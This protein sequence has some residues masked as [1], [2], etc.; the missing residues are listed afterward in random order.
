MRHYSV[1][2]LHVA[3]RPS[4]M[5]AGMLGGVCLSVVVLLLLLPLPW[6]IKCL[7]GAMVVAATAWHLGRYAWSAQTITALELEVSGKLRCYSRAK[8]WRDVEVLGSSFVTPKLTVLN[9][10]LPGERLSRHVVLLP[11]MVESA[12]FRRL[13]VWLRWGKD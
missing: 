7:C 10:R 4:R 9:F 12:A 6:W 8:D 3:L 13:R 2:P 5:L 11:D 1:K